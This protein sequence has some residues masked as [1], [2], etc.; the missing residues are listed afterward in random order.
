LDT[1]LRRIPGRKDPALAAKYH[2][3]LGW[4]EWVPELTK[5]YELKFFG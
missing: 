1:E 2:A 4:V 3:S 5:N